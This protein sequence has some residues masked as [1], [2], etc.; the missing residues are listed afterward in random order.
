MLSQF[1]YSQNSIILR[2]KANEQEDTLGVNIVNE[3]SKITYA[4]IRD[5][6]VQLWDSPKKEVAIS[7][8]SLTQIEKSSGLNF[9]DQQLIYIYEIWNN[10]KKKLTSETKGFL[11]STKLENGEA[12]V[13][14]YVDY[15]GLKNN[16]ATSSPKINPN[17]DCYLNLNTYLSK[18]KYN[19]QILQFG[20]KVINNISDSKL[21]KE[22]FIGTKKFNVESTA[23][24]SVEAKYIEWTLSSSEKLT[25]TKAQASRDFTN[26]LT[27]YFQQNLEVLYNLSGKNAEEILQNGTWKILSV[28]FAEI[29]KKKDGVVTSTPLW[30][31]VNIDSTVIDSIYMD[32]LVN[33]DFNVNNQNWL[34]YIQQKNFLY[35]IVKVNSDSIPVEKSIKYQKGLFT[36]KW[37]NLINFVELY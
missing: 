37:N 26:A 31:S 5:G 25:G 12:V 30:M 32:N 10:E 9:I 3:I 33:W 18:K 22:S 6:K 35:L 1:S 13:F 36:H 15:E 7:F 29:W 24:D 21:I 4:S 27:A 14:G 17:G 34:D 8:S 20:D 23:K 11:F 2:V 16:I 28:S 19:Y